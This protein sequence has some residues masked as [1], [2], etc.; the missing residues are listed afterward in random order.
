MARKRRPSGDD[1]TVARKRFYRKAER[2]LKDAERTSGATAQRMR[3]LAKQ[4]LNEAL[5][6]YS[7]KTTQEFSK[8]IRKLAADLG[9][10]LQDFRNKLKKQGEGTAKEIREAAIEIGRESR[11]AGSLES[12]QKDAETRRQAE[13]RAIL[14][15]PI[16]KRIIGGTEKIWRD[17]ASV[18]T[19]KGIKIDK[20][21]ILPALFEY[22]NVDNLGD[23]ITKAEQVIGETLYA[24][25]DQDAMYEAAKILMQTHIATDNSH[26]V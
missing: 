14:N 12:R 1:A 23:L 26:T 22:F 9:V 7:Q 10:N 6:T 2:Y 17:V 13:A 21:K 19:D 15:S 24:A 16:G 5:R 25:D 8:P 11:S 20:Y 3:Y 4:Q 18:Q